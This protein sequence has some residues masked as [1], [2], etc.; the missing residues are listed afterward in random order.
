MALKEQKVVEIY[1]ILRKEG[2]IMVATGAAIVTFDF[3][4]RPEI[5]KIGWE[6]DSYKT[7]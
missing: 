4:C 7:L 1:K 3:I 5:L 6:I 2:D